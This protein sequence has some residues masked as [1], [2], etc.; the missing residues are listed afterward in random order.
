MDL[1]SRAP[2][3]NPLLTVPITPMRTPPSS[4]RRILLLGAH[5][6]VGTAL[7]ARLQ[8]LG[9]V[10]AFGRAQ[11]DFAHPGALRDIVMAQRP[12]IIVNAAAYTAV[13]RAEAEP[14][15]A[16]T[17]NADSPGALASAA[18]VLDALLVHYSTDYVF[19]GRKATPYVEDDATD[20]QNVYGRSKRD[21][22]DAIRASDA[23][24][25]ILRTSWVYAA[26]GNNF[27][28]TMLRLA[29]ER[30]TLRVVADQTGAP[31]S[32]ELI[33]GATVQCLARM[34]PASTTWDGTYHL[35]AAG[36][37]SW[38]GLAERVVAEA[39]ARLG[40]DAL[41]VRHIEALTTAQ[42]PTP[43]ARPA[44]SQLCCDRLRE[45]FGID[46]P[47]WQD[48]VTQVVEQLLR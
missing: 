30:D 45:R 18:R 5:G 3:A 23:R 14:A 17:V 4:P 44:N 19:D 21:G 2:D 29:R 32:A 42:Y 10:T 39:R 34:P 25:L 11:A 40:A 22:E 27:V 43:A 35:T 24:H 47:A 7:A 37:T 48:G 6:Q 12:D 36:A 9:E 26:H 38:H 31:T 1:Q 15:L 20:P 28:R 41:A 13:D 8:V 33:A 46:L 16:Q